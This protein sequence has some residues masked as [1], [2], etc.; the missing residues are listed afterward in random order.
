MAPDFKTFLAT[1]VI[2]EKRTVSY[3]N[4]SR[5]L[6]VHINAA[7][8]ILF[9][10]YTDENK[11]KPG[12]VHATY[13]IAGRKKLRDFSGDEHDHAK[14][15]NGDAP[16]PSSP[17]PIPSS[18]PGASQNT[19]QLE[20]RYQI[21]IRSV[22]LCREES[23]ELVKEQYEQITSIHIHSLSPVKVQDLTTLTETGRTVF[24]DY[25]AKQDPLVHN[26]EYGLIQNSH[27]WRRQGKRPA[28]IDMPQPK[29]Q[30]KAA[31]TSKNEPSAA[32]KSENKLGA[33]AA[34]SSRPS[35]RDSTTTQ[36]STSKSKPSL[37]RDDSSLFKAFAKQ[38]TKPKL[39]RKDTDTSAAS[40]TRMSGMDDNDEGESEDEAMFLDTGTTK[41]KKRPSDA[42]KER[43]ERQAKLRK[44]M[45]DDDDADEAAVPRVDDAADMHAEP[46]ATKT[47]EDADA[48]DGDADVAWSD[49]DTEKKAS[50]ASGIRKQE[51]EEPKRRR[52][53]RKVMKKRT[54][55]DDEGFLVTREEEAW[56]S[57]SEEDAP[58]P[59]KKAAFPAPKSSA[60]AKSQ[61]QK[62]SAPKSSTGGTAKKKDIMS[63]FGKK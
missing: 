58:Q 3:R 35:S 18:M 45:D 20:E 9:E 29:L 1:E 4:V 62:S 36:D 14:P 61:T 55:K 53:K 46:P 48:P 23:L 30:S 16:M 21:P 42:Q 49:S 39:E 7:K 12:S 15:V 43:E 51:D 50:K 63:F 11:K 10:F 26:K 47:G 32:V 28:N 34:N 19:E 13:L 37:K 60:P 2:S 44:M 8:C 41:G 27:V 40:D 38:T 6:K 25:H 22:T 24:V 31:M 57:F 33:A 17:P 56:E 59:A 54:M 5:A 52:G